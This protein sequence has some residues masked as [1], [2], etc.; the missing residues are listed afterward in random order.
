MFCKVNF[1]IRN[2]EGTGYKSKI[3][4]LILLSGTPGTGQSTLLGFG[5]SF[6]YILA[7]SFLHLFLLLFAVLPKTT[8][9]KSSLC[10]GLANKLSI[11]LNKHYPSL[12]FHHLCT[13]TL[14]SKF[15]G[16]SSQRIKLLFDS[17]LAD[18]RS[19][20]KTFSIVLI[21]EIDSLAA[22]RSSASERG[23]VGDAVRAANAL[24]TGLDTILGIPNVLVLCTSNLTDTLDE[25]FLDR[26]GKHV[27]I[28]PPSACAMYEILKHELAILWRVGII[29][30]WED[31]LSNYFEA[32][33][34]QMGAPSYQLRKIV[35]KLT[36]KEAKHL[37]I[38]A[39]WLGRLPQEAMC[40]EMHDSDSITLM[41][42][43]ANLLS[44]VGKMIISA[45]SAT[46]NGTVVSRRGDSPP[47]KNNRRLLEDVVNR[48]GNRS[49]VDDF[50]NLLKEA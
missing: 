47:G 31:D 41:E 16:E 30:D 49:R 1:D 37:N 45:S 46:E 15:F 21:D 34:E 10:L 11:R 29:S 20:P 12:N 6:S 35:D 7:H 40:S 4:R 32:A 43:V 18:S 17:L 39:R 27:V 36:G 23:E 33:R 8:A 2:Y 26:C 48:H 3:N 13:S 28:P 9:G 24:L 50:L 44:H 42:A 25:A 5:S 38:S 14:L 19:S 22:S